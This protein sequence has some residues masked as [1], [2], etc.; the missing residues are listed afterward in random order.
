MSGC[1]QRKIWRSKEY[2][3]IVL[4]VH[5][6]AQTENIQ[7]RPKIAEDAEEIS[8]KGD[9]ADGPTGNL[10]YL[11]GTCRVSTWRQRSES[12][13]SDDSEETT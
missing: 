1:F 7:D 11:R 10:E 5:R 8:S 9:F 4:A 2:W 13:F 3:R 6:N 12:T